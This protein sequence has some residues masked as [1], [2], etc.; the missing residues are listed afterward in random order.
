[1]RAS[2]NISIDPRF[3]RIFGTLAAMILAIVIGLQIAVG[4][5]V[6]VALVMLAAIATLGMLFP[7]AVFFGTLL[8]LPSSLTLP[9]LPQQVNLHYLA[10]VAVLG[11]LLAFI[12]LLRVRT[13]FNVVHGI[14]L[15]IC[16]L[17][18]FLIMTRGLGFLQFG[19]ANVGGVR[20]LQVFSGF[21]LFCA[22]S[23]MVISK[24]HWKW[25]IGLWIIASL[26][27]VFAD[28]M[29]YRGYAPDKV[30]M[31]IR[32]NDQT[33][34]A[35]RV[36]I[37][38]LVNPDLTRFF[39]ANGASYMIGICVLCLFRF[40]DFFRPKAIFAVP[41]VL[42]TFFLAAIS[43]FRLAILRL[44]AFYPLAFFVRGEMKVS[45]IVTVVLLIGL[46]LGAILPFAERL[47][48]NIQRSLAFIPFIELHPAAERDATGT[49]E[50]RIELWRRAVTEIPDHLLIGKGFTFPVSEF[51]FNRLD[52]VEWA[53][54]SSSYHNGPLSTLI[55]L[56]IPGSILV[57]L[58]FVLSC[59]HL[60]H[61]YKR[62]WN[63]EELRHYFSV[64]MAAYFVNWGVFW[65]VYGD[66]AQDLAT[67]F[68][69]L[70]IMEA[71]RTSDQRSEHDAAS[72]DLDLE[73]TAKTG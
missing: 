50:W 46:S 64:F 51:A 3:V 57:V 36:A 22:A 14:G 17:L 45:R 41:A 54:I 66:I 58:L 21:T 62:Q 13:N 71:I 39:A 60:W 1:M 6:L 5:Y 9:G 48:L 32:P 19:S 31:F 30:T 28:F 29:L 70:A 73:D 11:N 72:P 59:H 2:S 43:G 55:M 34:G 15:I 49:F 27:P 18:G 44:L 10:S 4:A 61:I 52:S 42:I 65:F 25:L 12:F 56:G 63:T 20:Y 24:Q 37:R 53:L 33:S 7:R 40:H 69:N 35:A 26:I 67:M 23:V 38:D 68:V 16:A 8:L 47:P